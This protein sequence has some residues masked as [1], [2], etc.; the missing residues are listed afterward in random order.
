M[1]SSI[2]QLL[3]FLRSY[4]RIND[5]A[6][7]AKL[8][9]D[10]FQLTKDRSVYYCENFAVRFS[11]SATRNFGNTVLSLSNLQKFDDAGRFAWGT[12][13]PIRLVFWAKRALAVNLIET[14][15]SSDQVVEQMEDG[16]RICASLVDSMLLRQWLRGHGKMVRVL[17]PKELIE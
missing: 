9:S 7:L 6:K 10:T 5:K 8:V 1:N 4:D 15:L 12:G 17:E 2:E 3:A 14:P 11:S 16:Y 13:H